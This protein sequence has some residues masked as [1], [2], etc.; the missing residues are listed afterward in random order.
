MEWLKRLFGN[1]PAPA[2]EAPPPAPAPAP[3][4]RHETLLRQTRAA[5]AAWREG[6]G[7]VDDDLIA[8]AINPAFQGAPAWPNMRQAFCIIRRPDS[9]IITSD[10][11]AEP[12]P[13]Q[14]KGP[15]GV[16]CEV[17]IEIP[18][19]QDWGFGDIRRSWAF[20]LIEITARNVAHWGGVND[21]LAQYGVISTEM[22]VDDF[23]TPGWITPDGTIGV[24]LGLPVA[25]RA[26]S[27]DLPL[28]PA[29]MVPVTVLHPDELA[30]IRTGGPEARDQIA[31][32]LGARADGHLS[33][34][35]RAP[36]AVTP[37]G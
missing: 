25:G 18:G 33:V 31:A 22:P 36:V 10:G 28:G 17:Y 35:D 30:A 32:A 27:V 37:E 14:T 19:A 5:I 21:A 26:G 3:D 23:P 29:L 8:Y 7:T 16:G 24:L 12:G 2:A 11:L 9:L 13:D 20:A 34:P 15:S 4:D 6:L 1:R